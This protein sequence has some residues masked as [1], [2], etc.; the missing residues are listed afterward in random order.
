MPNTIAN[1]SIRDISFLSGLCLVFIL[2]MN[3]SSFLLA[4]YVDTIVIVGYNIFEVIEMSTTKSNVNVKIETRVKEQAVEL[5]ARMGIDQTTAIDMFYRQI[6]TLGRLPFTPIAVPSLD[7][8]LATAIEQSGIPIV[9]LD[10]DEKG[11]IIVD[12]DLHPEIYDWMVN[13]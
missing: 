5:L 9:E 1:V 7:E 12:K 3:R 13:G 8:R 4:S 2:S 10:V 11:H 6:I